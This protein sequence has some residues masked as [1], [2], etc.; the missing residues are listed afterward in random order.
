MPSSG[1]PYDINDR[2]GAIADVVAP[3]SDEPVVVK[4]YPSSFEKT[5]LDALLKGFGVEDVALAW[6]MTHVCVNSTARASFNHGYRA[7]N[8][9]AAQSIGRHRLCK[10]ASRSELGPAQRHLCRRGADCGR[11][12]GLKSILAP[13]M[14]RS[15]EVKQ[16][17][18]A[19][20]SLS[21]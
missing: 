8:T 17:D 13:E 16:K 14:R 15:P 19:M 5:N 18:P 12:S 4:N 21:N 10:R 6:F 7:T 9:R 20:R 11:F 3:R 1:S 2:I